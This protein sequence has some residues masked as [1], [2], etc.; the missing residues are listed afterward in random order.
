MEI[1]TLVAGEMT[2]K[3]FYLYDER[4]KAKSDPE[5]TKYIDKA[6]E[7]SGVSI[8]P[9]VSLSD[10]LLLFDI[11]ILVIEIMLCCSI[12][13][14]L[15]LKLLFVLDSASKTLGQWYHRNDSFPST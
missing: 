14:L 13:L 2:R 12:M 5:I 10:P 9:K 6:R 7:I 4:R 8:D 3:G 11:K 1:E 15:T